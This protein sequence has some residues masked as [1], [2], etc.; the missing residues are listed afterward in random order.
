MLSETANLPT[1]APDGHDLQRPGTVQVNPDRRSRFRCQHGPSVENTVSIQVATTAASLVPDESK[2]LP[3][4][5]AG[6]R[7]TIH[8]RILIELR[9]TRSRVRPPPSSVAIGRA[10]GDQQ[11]FGSRTRTRLASSRKRSRV[12][13][14]SSVVAPLSS[15]SSSVIC[16]RGCSCQ[17]GRWVQDGFAADNRGHPLIVAPLLRRRRP[18]P[19]M[20]AHPRQIVFPS[21]IRGSD[22]C[23]PLQLCHH[24]APESWE[25]M[26]RTRCAE[27]AQVLQRRIRSTQTQL[28]ALH[29]ASLCCLTK[30]R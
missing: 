6:V 8:R 26:C 15:S 19:S 29:V 18:H 24:P 14:R 13:T 20:L 12:V 22:S 17:R 1:P 4:A 9:R 11:S 27:T 7:R 2:R 3:S 21:K 5:S 10:G 25:R 28:F 16:C 23:Y 30:L